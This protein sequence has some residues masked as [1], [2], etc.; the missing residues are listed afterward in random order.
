MLDTKNKQKELETIYNR[1]YAKAYVIAR[2]F[3]KNEE[4]A[5]DILQEAYISVFN[6]M[7]SLQDESKLDKWVNMIVANR[8]KDWL[9]KK[10][11]VLFSDMGEEAEDD[12]E[13]TIE[14]NHIE[15]LPEASV[16]YAETK[17]LIAEILDALPE[18][19]RMC[20]LMYYYDELSVNEIAESLD[21]STG[22][23]KSRLNY[24]RKKIKE[25]VEAL[26]KKGTKLYGIAPLPFI[27]WMLKGVE[28]NVAPALK[29]VNIIQGAI[30]AGVSNL[31][32]ATVVKK[33]QMLA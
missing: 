32:K 24:A 26:E 13:A 9:R 14:D 23:V 12:Y 27:V 1:T 16:D 28:T 7:E 17:R 33:L 19:Q 20:I 21:C 22:T 5:L 18:D 29:S 30:G 10:Q 3:V 6:H 11:V 2:Q 25:E 31:G 4:D 8:C 15:F